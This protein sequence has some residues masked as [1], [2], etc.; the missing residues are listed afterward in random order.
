MSAEPSSWSTVRLVAERE[1]RT[2]LRDK[3]FRTSTLIMIVALGIA[4]VLP[5]VAGL[6][7][8][9]VG[10]V[11]P[12][13]REVVVAAQAQA[14]LAKV[15]ITIE[16]LPDDE[17]ARERAGSGDI[18]AAVTSDGAVVTRRFLPQQLKPFLLSAIASTELEDRLESAGVDLTLLAP[19]EPRVES[20]RGEGASDGRSRDIAFFVILGLLGVLYSYAIQVALGVVEEKS[21]RV[22]EVVLSA[23]RPRQL[24][25]GK[26]LGVG[27]VGL[28]QIAIVGTL[29][30]AAAGV[31]GRIE[32]DSST[33]GT[34]AQVGVWFLLGYALFAAAAAALGATV[35][36]Q[37]DTQQVLT[38]LTAVLMASY[39]L[40][41]YAWQHPTTALTSVLSYL[42]PFS[43]LVMTPRWAGG[44]AQLWQVGLSMAVMV[45]A[46]LLVVRLGARVY[47]GAV[48]RLGAPVTLR[49][50]LSAGRRAG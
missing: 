34:F 22:V 5:S 45:A 37:E 39:V 28:L 25:V 11:G 24:L 44:E 46:I 6:T 38:V 50:A 41:F 27:L 36:R 32:L 15:T 30:G 23:I 1:L 16:E 26:I 40:G 29:A 8:F 10:V 42:P 17:A 14:Q 13:A 7:R 18:A 2:R 19:V 35:S 4:V 31:T 48:L 43:L 33:V 9:T 49:E 12:Q 21:S 3:A 20:L 47:E